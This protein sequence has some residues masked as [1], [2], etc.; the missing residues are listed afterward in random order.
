[1]TGL[2]AWT[3]EDGARVCHVTPSTIR[4]WI[5]VGWLPAWKQGGRWWFTLKSLMDAEFKARLARQRRLGS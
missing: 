2:D 1:M 5:R 3:V 4:R